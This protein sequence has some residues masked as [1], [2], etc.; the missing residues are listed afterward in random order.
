MKTPIYKHPGFWLAVAMAVLQLTNFFRTMVDPAGFAVYMGL[1]I[2]DIADIAWVQVYGFR[3]L[4][5]GL[6]VS[7]F[8][9]KVDPRSLKWIAAL[10]IVMAAGD[11][12]LVSHTGGTT[13]GRHLS[14]AGVLVIAIFALHRWDLAM[15]SSKK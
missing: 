15:A 13:T 5:I 9:F 8:L 12:W 10:A 3:A 1:P 11:A 4:F 2:K 7:F 14:T 6:L